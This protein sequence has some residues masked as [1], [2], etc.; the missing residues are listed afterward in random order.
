VSQ[1]RRSVGE[2]LAP[3]NHRPWEEV[4]DR[5]N[6]KLRAGKHTS[7]WAVRL[8]RIGAIDE[9]VEERVRYFLRRGTRCPRKAPAGS[10]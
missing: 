6:Q 10:P 3:G 5:L 4:R 1:M 9:Y 8:G 2:H 7:N